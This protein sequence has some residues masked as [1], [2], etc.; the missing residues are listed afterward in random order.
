M[1]KIGT[2]KKLLLEYNRIISSQ[3]WHDSKRF[4]KLVNEMNALIDS[5]SRLE[6]NQALNE[7]RILYENRVNSCH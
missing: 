1:T 3:E 5:M 6:I 7:Q 4:D 2:Y